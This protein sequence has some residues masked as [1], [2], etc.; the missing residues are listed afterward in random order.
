MIEREEEE[1]EIKKR[2]YSLKHYFTEDILFEIIKN[3]SDP[4]DYIYLAQTCQYFYETML[5]KDNYLFNYF[6]DILIN[7]IEL[8][9]TNDLPNYLFKLKKL[10]INSYDNDYSIL[11]NFTNVITLMSA[12]FFGNFL[13]YLPN[14]EEL[15]VDDLY[16][17]NEDSFT[18]L[19]QLK[20]L[21]IF[22][23][24]QLQDEWLKNLNNLTKLAICNKNNNIHRKLC[25]TINNEL[26]SHCKQLETLIV[27]GCDNIFGSCFKEFKEL[28]N[29]D[30]SLC[31][32]IKDDCLNDLNNLV[33]LQIEN[34]NN[35]TGS[36]LQNLQQLKILNITVNS[37]MQLN[38]LQYLINLKNLH[39]TIES[40]KTNYKNIKNTSFLT[41]LINLKYLFIEYFNMND[42]IDEFI[43]RDEDFYNV[44]NL[45]DL[46][47]S[48]WHDEINTFPEFTGKCFK[49]FTK[50]KR[51]SCTIKLEL[52][53][54]KY[55]PNIKY[56]N[57]AFFEEA[58]H[59]KE[60]SCLKSL[61]ELNLS[62]VIELNLNNLQ[63]FTNLKQIKITSSTVNGELNNLPNLT[64]LELWALQIQDKQIMNL[65]NLTTL[66]I[67]ECHSING[68]CFLNLGRLQALEVSFCKTI[69]FKYLSNLKQLT[70]LIISEVDVKEE[71]L[72]G[73]N[74][75]QFLCVPYCP[76]INSSTGTFL[77]N[78]NKL[79]HLEWAGK[80][81]LLKTEM[82]KLKNEIKKGNTFEQSI[83]SALNIKDN[84]DEENNEED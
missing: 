82:E 57:L 63:L 41:K 34:C 19:K 18:N 44:K 83:C 21:S 48:T 16:D 2:K 67:T 11:K 10:R 55:L 58:M 73:L 59:F 64:T 17:V 52:Q 60:F 42:N 69:N 39:I 25:L 43:F 77:L 7:Q 65:D 62:F 61:E 80:E 35:I 46:T 70:E 26:L 1:R 50:L 47:I 71:D 74:N 23:K 36:C 15:L 14:L 78:M 84:Q 53:H 32:N 45:K 8:K 51:L 30:V 40:D 31:D 27:P 28:K 4:K 22:N 81:I 13:Q 6:N 66:K 75:I 56:L 9:L 33:F 37:S 24:N 29:L 54:F 3:L 68:E 38:Y 49:Y 79:N 20:V 5:L 76:Y 72:I 12:S